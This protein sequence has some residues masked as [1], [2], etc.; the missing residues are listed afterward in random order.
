MLVHFYSFLHFIKYRIC[1]NIINFH[2]HLPSFCL[3]LR[4]F[5]KSYLTH[6]NIPPLGTIKP[7]ILILEL[8]SFYALKNTSGSMLPLGVIVS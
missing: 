8:Y 7:H 1:Q 3:D 4:I 5:G 2:S 6:N